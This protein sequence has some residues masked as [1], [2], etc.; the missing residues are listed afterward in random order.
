MLTQDSIEARRIN[1]ACCALD[2]M[3][4]YEQA[5]VYGDTSPCQ[6]KNYRLALYMHWAKSVADRIS[7]DA[8]SDWSNDWNDDWNTDNEA[9]S[10]ITIAFA[11][12][13]FKK[14]DCYCTSCGCG[15]ESETS[16]YPPPPDP[17]AP[18]VTYGA[19]A[20]VDVNDRVSIQAGPPAVGD[21][22]FVVT[23]TGG[24]GWTVNTLVEWNGTGWDVTAIANGDI[25][26]VGGGELWTTLG[27][28][29]PGLLYPTVTL[30]WV[31]TQPEQYV[32]QSDYPQVALFTGRTAIVELLTPGG[33]V[34]VFQ[35][36]EADLAAPIPFD[37]TGFS[38]TA[39]TVTYIDG[40]C[41]WTSTTGNIEPPGCVF[42]G[43]FSCD[44]FSIEDFF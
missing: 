24:T 28:D 17:C 11:E 13:V 31:G 4:K 23:D 37:A 21:T 18:T 29:L 19:L 3:F 2:Y 9:T 10:C 34:G 7:I 8:P 35:G 14:A 25:I 30:T 20:A 33:W 40:D 43:D 41:S 36:P 44:D 6:D 26:D 15:T 42:P 39:V 27:W 5:Q 16:V 38:F 1:Y 22:Y 12:A 32:L